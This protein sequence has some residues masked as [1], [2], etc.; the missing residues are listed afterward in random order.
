MSHIQDPILAARLEMDGAM[1]PG[2]TA[3]QYSIG[4]APDTAPLVFV[5]R[6][7][8]ESKAQWLS[9]KDLT[10]NRWEAQ[11]FTRGNYCRAF[12]YETGELGDDMG[13]EIV[14]P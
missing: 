3:M 14:I 6:Y 5:V 11:L 2:M 12:D 9:K 1:L 7:T 8:A 10:Y 4:R 13:L